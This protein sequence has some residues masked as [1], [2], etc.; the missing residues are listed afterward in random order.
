MDEPDV[1]HIQA[2][3]SVF[4]FYN[5]FSQ[6]GGFLVVG[7]ATL[8]AVMQLN[9]E[10]LMKPVRSKAKNLRKAFNAIL[11]SLNVK[12][13]YH[14][15]IV[16]CTAATTLTSSSSSGPSQGSFLVLSHLKRT[17]L[18]EAGKID[19]VRFQNSNLNDPSAV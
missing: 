10:L 7:G 11:C 12:M 1:Y 13:L 8:A 3:Q 17:F 5:Q 16:S 15:R 4:F 18:L 19:G 6:L 2:D 9:F 14:V